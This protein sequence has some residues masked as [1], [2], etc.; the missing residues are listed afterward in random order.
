MT[1][2]LQRL[3]LQI[4]PLVE[5]LGYQLWNL[6]LEGRG[7]NQRLRITID[8]E[9]GIGLDDC[10][11]VSRE[12]SALMDVEDPISG[13]YHL[14]V[15]SPGLDRV[16]VKPAHFERFVGSDVR[17]TLFEPVA[18]KRKL[19]GRLAAFAD[20]VITLAAEDTDVQVQVELVN[21]AKAR[22]EPDYDAQ[23][24]QAGKSH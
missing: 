19:K 16:L 1:T 21:V 14:E 15:S 4:E 7:S 20:A 23:A 10:E 22:V 6:E 3:E 24:S 5:G 18:G 2:L 11:Q 8:A 9:A 12:V 13:N 17:L